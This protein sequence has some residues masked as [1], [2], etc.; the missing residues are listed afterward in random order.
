M[1]N[2][3][4]DVRR[5]NPHEQWV[6]KTATHYTT[7]RGVVSNRVRVEH[8]TLEAC[9]GWA[10]RNHGSD[11]RTMIYAVNHLGNHAHLRNA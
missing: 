2:A 11:G 7:I 10:E 5:L 9:L 4:L 6:A 3:K 1:T 8:P